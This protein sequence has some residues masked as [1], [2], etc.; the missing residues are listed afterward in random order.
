[1]GI[2]SFEKK[3]LSLPEF[4]EKS[5]PGKGGLILCI[6]IRSLYKLLEQVEIFLVDVTV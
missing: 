4:C 6:K 5:P 3:L 2:I 1:M